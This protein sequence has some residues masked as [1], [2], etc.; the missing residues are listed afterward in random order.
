MSPPVSSMLRTS[1]WSGAESLTIGDSTSRSARA[2]MIVVPCSAMAPLRITRSPG[3]APAAVISWWC[4]TRP[5]PLV[6]MKHP[7]ALPRSTTLVS[8]VTSRTPAVF[9]AALIDSTIR[10]RSASG[11]P[12]SRMKAALR[13]RGRS[14]AIARSLTVPLTA[15]IPMAPPGKK[16]GV[17]TCPSVVKASRPPA[18]FRTAWSSSRSRYE[19][20]N[21]RKKYRAIRSAGIWPP[22]PPPSST[23]AGVASGAGQLG[24]K[25]AGPP[26]DDIVLPQGDVHQV[27]D[28]V[29]QRDVNLLDPVNAERRHDEAVLGQIQE[30]T[31]VLA[32][33][34]DGEKAQLPCG[35][36]RLHEI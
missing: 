29:V 31:S 27:P 36:E 18:T 9:A 19:F 4:A 16:S 1:S 3:R 22:L 24:A 15:S 30:A 35:L 12:S 5:T 7:S 17:T 23:R 14:P 32:G 11:K 13:Y 28:D 33:E 34:G 21:A 25:L 10:P 6:V 2:A 20:R 8:P 26:L